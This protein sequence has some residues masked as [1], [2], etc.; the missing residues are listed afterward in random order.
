MTELWEHD[1]WQLA[2]AVRAGER[3]RSTALDVSLDAHRGAQRRA[4]RGLLPR[5]ATAPARR[6]V[7]IDAAV[8]RRRGSRSVRGR[9]GRGE[10]ARA[11]EGVPEHPRVGRVP[12]RR[13]RGRLPRGRRAA[14]RRRRDHRAHDRARVG[15]PELHVVA[16]ARRSP[17]TRGTPSAT[18]GG[19]SGGSAAA[20]AAGLFPA[21]TGSDGGGSIRIPSSYSGLPGMKPTFGRIGARPARPVRHRP[22]LGARADGALGARRGALPR[23]HERARRSSDPTSLPKPDPVRAAR[24]R[25]STAARDLLRGKRVAWTS[26]LGYARDA[27]PTSRRLTLAAAEAADRRGRPRARRRRRSRSPSRGARGECSARRNTRGLALRPQRGGA[28]RPRLPRCASR[29]RGCRTSGRATS[30]PAIAPAPGDPRRVGRAVRADRPAPARPRHATTAYQAEGTLVGEVNGKE[31]G[32]HVSCR[33]AFTAP[34]NMTGQPGIQIPA[35]LVG[36]MPVRAAGRRPPPRG[37]PVP[38]R[39]RGARGGPALAQVRPR[40]R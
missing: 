9:A 38:G 17:A 12:G 5:R 3:P 2:D 35:G 40:L 16:A 21:C 7:E 18:P 10:G 1:A 14:G 29:S 36:G 19:S 4:E 31:R 11:G 34:F 24:R 39:R 20:V 32:P 6:A 33:R 25:R 27:T 23:R 8:A 22:H 13:R 28:R 15:D 37:R 30:A 26:T